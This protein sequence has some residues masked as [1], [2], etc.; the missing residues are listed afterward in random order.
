MTLDILKEIH[1]LIITEIDKRLELKNICMAIMKNGKR[2]NK[3]AKQNNLCKK[4]ENA[5]NVI[6][7]RQSF[8][9]VLYHT[10][11]PSIE[12]M[13]NCP[14]CLSLNKTKNRKLIQ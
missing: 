10:H 9:C 5:T 4:H 14:K 12:F 8:S 1:S 11:L 3:K 2:C 13:D 6:K 7:T